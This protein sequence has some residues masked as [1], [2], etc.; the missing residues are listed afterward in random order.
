M[1]HVL[2]PV[3]AGIPYLSETEEQWW[4]D[5]KGT[6]V[7]DGEPSPNSGFLQLIKTIAKAVRGGMTLFPSAR[8]SYHYFCVQ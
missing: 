1:V 4:K 2:P 5:K 7:S 3:L 6:D 8:P